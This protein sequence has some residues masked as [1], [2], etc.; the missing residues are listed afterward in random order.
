MNDRGGVVGME[1]PYQ[2]REDAFCLKIGRIFD[3]TPL[4]R[5]DNVKL[6]SIR[7]SYPF[8]TYVIGPF[9]VK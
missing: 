9:P 3:A 1:L 5:M 4:Q 7:L 8:H 6:K 2:D